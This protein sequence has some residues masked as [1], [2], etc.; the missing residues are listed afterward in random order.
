M[1]GAQSYRLSTVDTH[2]VALQP[3]HGKITQ[4]YSRYCAVAFCYV[5]KCELS[6]IYPGHDVKLHLPEWNNKYQIG[7]VWSG[8]V[9]VKTQ[10]SHRLNSRLLRL[11]NWS[12]LLQTVL[13]CFRVTWGISIVSRWPSLTDRTG[14]LPPSWHK[15]NF[16][17]WHAIK[18]PINQQY[19]L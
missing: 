11:C 9:L 17:C 12:V 18:Q 3:I 13:H 16:L 5:H 7:C 19:T 1:I 14:F 8:L 6:Y 4:H 2:T 15:L 10:V